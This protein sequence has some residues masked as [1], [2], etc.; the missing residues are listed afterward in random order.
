MK[1]YDISLPVY[2][3]MVH[4]PDNPPVVL[5][6]AL[7]IDKGDAANVSKLSAGVHTGTHVDAPVHFIPGGADTES[8]DLGVLVG[9]ALVVHLGDEVGDITA[10]VLDRAGIPAGT[11]RVLFR[12]RNSKYWARDADT[13]HD[14]FVAVR[15]DGAKWLVEHG[16][17]LVGVDYLSVAPFDDGAP[18]HR[19]LLQAGVI[20]LEGLNLDGIAGGIYQLVCL[21]LKLRGSDGAPV[22]AILIG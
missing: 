8:L 11:E 19:T 15:D 3:G 20:P 22:R 7:S 2:T 12:T 1:I 10:S 5:E 17:R 14:D 16:L 6:R 4:W 18:T 21:P 9:P 13:F